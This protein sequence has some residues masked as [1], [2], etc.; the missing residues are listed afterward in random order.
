MSFLH[1]VEIRENVTTGIDDEAG[2]S[3]LDGDRVHE[4]IVFGSFGKYVGDGGRRLAVDADVENLVLG[5]SGVAGRDI[6]R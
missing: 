5:E 3:T 6:S 2:T 4:E 1:D